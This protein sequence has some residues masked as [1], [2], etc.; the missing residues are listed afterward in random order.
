[1]ALARIA[2]V[3]SHASDTG[4][5]F[6]DTVASCGGVCWFISN[7]LSQQLSRL[8]KADWASLQEAY[9]QMLRVQDRLKDFGI[10]DFDPV[11]SEMAKHCK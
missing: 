11:V 7:A 1:M 2:G 10:E 5:V 3:T 8:A 6:H 4:Q 9:E